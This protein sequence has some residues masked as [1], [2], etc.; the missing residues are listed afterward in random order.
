MVKEK[1]KA[2]ADNPAKGSQLSR[3]DPWGRCKAAL[4]PSSYSGCEKCVII[5]NKQRRV[6]VREE[7]A[8]LGN[9]LHAR[10]RRWSGSSTPSGSASL[11]LRN[12]EWSS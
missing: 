7:K 1:R 8:R 12:L 2:S 10:L 4:S 11:D 6:L 3:A 5:D 9:G